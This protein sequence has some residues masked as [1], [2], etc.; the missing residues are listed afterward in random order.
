MTT[1]YA[2][3]LVCLC[4][5]K[6]RQHVEKYVTENDGT[7]LGYDAGRAVMDVAIPAGLTNALRHQP[8]VCY[9]RVNFT[10]CRK[11]HED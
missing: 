6:D 1:L 5:P 9:V 2:D 10:Y 11:S 3:A 8:G 7:L 4:N